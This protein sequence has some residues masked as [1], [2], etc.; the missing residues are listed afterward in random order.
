MLLLWFCGISVVAQ[1]GE[2]YKYMRLGNQADV[3]TK[4][5]YGA[6]LMGGGTDLDE[7]FKFLCVK[8]NGG[9]F[10]VLRFSGDDDYNSWING[11]CKLNSVST[12]I[13][14]S[15]EAAKDPRVGEII[16]HAEAVFIAGGDQS[17][18]L[19]LWT[20]TPVQEALNANIAEGKP[21]G[22]T[23]AGLAVLGQF[24]Y[25]AQGDKPDDADLASKDVLPNPF[26]PRVIVARDFLKVPNMQDT[27]TDTHFAKRDRL[28]RTLVF[29]SRIVQD[30]WSANPREIA[31][32][33]K[34]A[35]LVEA[36]GKGTVV[37]SG[38]GAYFLSVTQAPEVCK[39]GTPLTF[40]GIAVYK[41][42]T[43][44]HFDLPSWKGDGGTA[45]VLSVEQ[46]VVKSTQAGGSPY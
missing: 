8:A 21:I 34:S 7:A 4:P 23:S 32:D 35:V 1:G 6:A 30:G 38:K 11:L 18:Y 5:A 44:S 43:G 16:R 22:G 20:G 39:A 9:D 25:G 36:D 2:T 12:L 10:L 37:G 45:Y 24:I 31:V 15:E 17:H 26:H 13:I 29:L 42:P 40:H 33:E 46:G 27:L 19:N 3:V 41:A 28:G 14:P